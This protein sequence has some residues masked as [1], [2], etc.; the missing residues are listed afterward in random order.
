MSDNHNYCIIMAGGYGSR[1]W[2]ISRADKPKQFLTFSE[3]GKS[4]LRL[5]YERALEIVPGEN[6]IVVSLPKYQ[7]LVYADIPELQAENLILEPY[8]RNTAPCIAYAM[9]YLLKRDPQAVMFA[10]PADQ[11]IE[12]QEI[13][14]RT[15]KSALEYAAANQVLLT[16][17]IV[18][19]RPDHNFGYIQMAGERD[20]NNPVKVKTFTEKPDAELAKVFIESGEFLWNAGIFIW[21]ASVIASEMQKIYPEITRLWAGWEEKL[22]TAQQDAFIQRVY[23]DVP[24]ISIDYAVM[25]KSD[26]VMTIPSLFGWA[27]IGNWESFY[28]YI[29]RRDDN[30]NAILSTGKSLI[31]DNKG[32]V[33]YSTTGEKLIAVKGLKD[34]IVVDT[35]DILMI[36]PRDEKQLG[37]FIHELAMPSFEEY[38]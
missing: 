27:D 30:G 19:T 35:G 21:Q 38:R 28:E 34:Y 13:F 24:R 32:T 18:P 20:G 6:V 3:S 22:G 14:T 7:E 9:Y 33:V 37:E 10:V 15:V 36:A 17:G 8:N 26:K 5:A 11:A 4:F 25:E 12:D 29:T 31:Q 2:P 16:L 1:F 23:A